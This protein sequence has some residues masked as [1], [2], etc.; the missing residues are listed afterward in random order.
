[1]VSAKERLAL[2]SLRLAKKQWILLLFLVPAL[3]HVLLFNYL[4][5]L[6]I[7]IAFQDFDIL[8]GFAHSKFVGFAN[9]VEFF[10]DSE[11]WQALKNTV[12]INVICFVLVFPL[13]IALAIALNELI[14]TRFKKVVQSISYLPHFIS[15]VVVGGLFYR[16]LDANSGIVNILLMKLGHSPIPFFREP[17]FFWAII[18]LATIWK[19]IGWNSILYLAALNAI[20]PTLYEAAKVDGA[21]RFQ[22]IRHISLPGISTTVI[23]L[24]ILTVS[25][26]ISGN[27]GVNGTMTPNLDAYLN[28][29]NPLVAS[30]SDVIDVINYYKGVLGS[31]YSYATA[32]GLFQSVFSLFVLFTVNFAA[33]K[34]RG[35]SVL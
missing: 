5:M 32:I 21:N 28:M 33:K 30:S 12:G 25:T 20:D 17:H 22:R 15:W 7:T 8:S 31:E 29:R 27:G 10:E 9:F 2:N 19:E 24:F 35:A 4:P 14:G 6:G 16:M 18:V 11:F 3:V 26:I 23:L 34:W 1:M 13:P